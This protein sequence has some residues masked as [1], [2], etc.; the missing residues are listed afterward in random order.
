MR[1]PAVFLNKFHLLP[2]LD[3]DFGRQLQQG[4]LT[5]VTAFPIL[6]L[7][8]LPTPVQPLAN[9]LAPQVLC[10]RTCQCL[11]SATLQSAHLLPAAPFTCNPAP[12]AQHAS[13]LE[14]PTALPL[15][16][17]SGGSARYLL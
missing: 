4:V 14:D 17:G 6:S 7:C 15:V 16:P 1:L 5:E 3:Q 9:L 12:Q 10:R 11:S 8:P 13:H 2:I